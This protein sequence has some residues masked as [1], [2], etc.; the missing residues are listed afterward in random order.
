M[1]KDEGI[2]II[3]TPNTY[4]YSQKP[5]YN[6]FLN[7]FHLKEVSYGEFKELLENNFK[8]VFIYGQK[9][10]PTSNIFPISK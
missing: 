10:N 2:F 4:I 5:G 1:L 7:P 6:V 3:S 8:E 9:V